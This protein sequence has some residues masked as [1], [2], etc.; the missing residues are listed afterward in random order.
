MG[1]FDNIKSSEELFAEY[2]KLTKLHHPDLFQNE[3]DDIIESQTEIIAEI[4]QEFEQRKKEFLNKSSEEF[5]KTYSVKSNIKSFFEKLSPETKK[6]GEKFTNS[7]WDFINEM[8]K[9]STNKKLW[10]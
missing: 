9:E 3:G 5:E 6:Y 7:G 1:W 8:M 2:K 10:K 4:N